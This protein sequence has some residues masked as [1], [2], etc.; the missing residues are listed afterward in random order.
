[1]LQLGKLVLQRL[2]VQLS[3]VNMKYIFILDF[4]NNSNKGNNNI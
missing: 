1:M 3:H 2:E 4:V